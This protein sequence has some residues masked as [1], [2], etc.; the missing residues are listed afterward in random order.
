M[1]PSGVTQYWVRRREKAEEEGRLNRLS[2]ET[3]SAPSLPDSVTGSSESSK[4]ASTSDDRIQIPVVRHPATG[5]V[6]IGGTPHRYPSEQSQSPA[7]RQHVGSLSSG[8]P[9]VYESSSQGL[10]S[11]L[12]LQASSDPR[13]GVQNE[14]LDLSSLRIENTAVSALPQNDTSEL[15]R[16]V[17]QQ[18]HMDPSDFHRW[19][20]KQSQIENISSDGP[21]GS[22]TEQ[23]DAQAARGSGTQSENT[24]ARET[25]PE[26][27]STNASPELSPTEKVLH[28]IKNN[29]LPLVGPEIFAMAIERFIQDREKNIQKALE[30]FKP[31]LTP[32][33]VLKE[34]IKSPFPEEKCTIISCRSEGLQAIQ[35]KN[36][37]EADHFLGRALDLHEWALKVATNLVSDESSLDLSVENYLEMI[38]YSL[39]RLYRGAPIYNRVQSPL[40]NTAHLLIPNYS[41]AENALY[42]AQDILNVEPPGHILQG[43]EFQGQTIRALMASLYESDIRWLTLQSSTDAR[44]DKYEKSTRWAQLRF[45]K[46]ERVVILYRFE[47][48][49]GAVWCYTGDPTK[50]PGY[51]KD[52]AKF[53]LIPMS[54]LLYLPHE[55]IRHR[56][57]RLRE[58]YSGQLPVRYMVSVSEGYP[59]GPGWFDFRTAWCECDGSKEGW[60][61]MDPRKV[62]SRSG[63]ITSPGAPGLIQP[64]RE[65]GCKHELHNPIKNPLMRCLH[66]ED[67][68]TAFTIF[69]ES[70]RS[71]KR[72]LVDILHG[73]YTIRYRTWLI[74]A[75]I[76]LGADI[77]D[78]SRENNYLTPL[79]WAIN[80]RCG[81][82][83][84]RFLLD[85]G[86][87]VTKAGRR[88]SHRGIFVGCTTPIDYLRTALKHLGPSGEGGAGS[89]QMSQD[90]E[91]EI[92]GYREVLKVM[93]E[94]AEQQTEAEGSRWMN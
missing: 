82:E 62:L 69:D 92:A 45:E 40:G 55:T 39:S 75:A 31:Y 77:N 2:R 47:D 90:L 22:R 7:N 94:L 76:F 51:Y 29:L 88:G 8:G 71:S 18:E 3:Q 43:G 36:Y 67:I 1:A 70:S 35:N 52:G 93:E 44:F 91:K 63:I 84:L 80:Y 72:M 50:D 66:H 4:R 68:G 83:V 11:E 12:E 34:A 64:L 60:D 48:K 15:A 58:K 85:R 27:L 23:L 21:Q 13:S 14:S 42:S 30:I 57:R 32:F 59:E 86:A 37:E 74:S 56:A 9:G 49:E 19:F 24:S 78:E 38:V 20:A 53:G 17:N 73:N 10:P 79:H 61:R 54:A 89:E 87:N 28:D 6:L 25:T 26:N 81:P 46:G 5:R 16:G 33:I 65:P 41:T